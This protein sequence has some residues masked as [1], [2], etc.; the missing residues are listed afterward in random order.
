MPSPSAPRLSF[1]AV[2][3]LLCRSHLTCSS[4][5][6][7]GP[8]WPRGSKEH[9]GHGKASVRSRSEKVSASRASRVPTRLRGAVRRVGTSR[10][11]PVERGLLHFRI[12]RPPPDLV[13][14]QAPRKTAL[15]R[16]EPKGSRSMSG[17]AVCQRMCRARRDSRRGGRGIC[18]RLP[19]SKP[20]NIGGQPAQC[21]CGRTLCCF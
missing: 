5:G 12:C 3:H 9:F 21:F 1:G 20:S 13:P 19:Q 15:A 10:R 7:V 18:S 2:C 11:R 16:T 14:P 4:C 17:L 6:G 8:A